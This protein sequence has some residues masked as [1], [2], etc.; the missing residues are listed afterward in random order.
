VHPKQAL[1]L[2]NYGGAT[3]QDIKN[4]ADKIIADIHQKYEIV[5]QPEVNFI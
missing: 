3:G 5:L 1:V 4:L 2:V